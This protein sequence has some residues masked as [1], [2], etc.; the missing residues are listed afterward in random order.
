MIANDQSRSGDKSCVNSNSRR[1]SNT[2]IHDGYIAFISQRAYLKTQSPGK[3]AVSFFD[4]W[5]LA[6]HFLV[7]LNAQSQNPVFNWI[8]MG[9]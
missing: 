3:F 1:S 2:N 4:P 9:T 6:G 8:R 7:L 5:A